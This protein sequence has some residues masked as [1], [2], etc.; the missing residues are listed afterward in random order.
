MSPSMTPI[1]LARAAA[2]R[3][4]VRFGLLV[5]LA[6]LSGCAAISTLNSASQSLD[7][8]DLSASVVPPGAPTRSSR[9]L[10]VATPTASSAIATDRMVIKPNPLQIKYLP[11]GRWVDAAPMHVQ[12][13]LIRSI[14]NSG[15]VAFVGGD[16]A[17]PLP[18]YVLLTDLQAFQAEVGPPSQVLVRMSLT[19]V[20]DIDR[21]VIASRTFETTVNLGSTDAMPVAA[22]FNAAMAGLLRQATV[23]TVSAMGGRVS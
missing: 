23:W 5:G 9:V 6:A 8:F 12:A 18:D 16:T 19:L 3:L 22:A 21:R 1:Q 11:D 20:R 17:G 7:T 4:V 15:G 2:V 13:L 14:G 10:L